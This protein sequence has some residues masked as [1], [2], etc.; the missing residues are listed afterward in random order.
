MTQVEDKEYNWLKNK[1]L[2]KNV[3]GS[4]INEEKVSNYFKYLAS[5]LIFMWPDIYT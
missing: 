5:P 4:S 3:A 1:D 2:E